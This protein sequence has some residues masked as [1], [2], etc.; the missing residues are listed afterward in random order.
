MNPELIM[1]ILILCLISIEIGLIIALNGVRK[2]MGMLTKSLAIFGNLQTDVLT[3]KKR[4][5]N[6]F[7][8]LTQLHE[9]TLIVK[10]DTKLTGKVALNVK[11]KP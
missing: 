4:L 6:F 7:A 8:H 5:N 1:S 2:N 3:I 9:G 11:L 10:G